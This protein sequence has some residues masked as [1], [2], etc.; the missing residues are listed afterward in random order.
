MKENYLFPTKS[1]VIITCEHA[2]NAIPQ[3]LK[4][5]FVN[6][7]ELLKQHFAYDI[8]ALEIANNLKSLSDYYLFATYSRLVVDLNRSLHHSNLFSFIT[9][10]LT[11]F[12]K[13]ELLQKFYEPYRQAIYNKINDYIDQGFCVLHFSIHSFTPKKH[14]CDVGLLYDPKRTL[15]KNIA[16]HWKKQI[17]KLNTKIIIRFNYPYKGKADGLTTFCRRHWPASQYIGLELEVN[18]KF[19]EKQNENKEMVKK[20]LYTSLKDTLET[21]E[22][23]M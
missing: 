10:P 20:V 22:K 13:T 8:G 6:H 3:E 23:S 5:L 1:I 17:N 18:Q 21:L 15:E 7:Q 2:T 16:L 12:K 4:A 19:F 9:K 11:T 14:Y